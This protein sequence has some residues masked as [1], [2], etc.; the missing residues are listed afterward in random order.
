M[1]KEFDLDYVKTNNFPFGI[2]PEL[3][4]LK[5]LWQ[6]YLRLETTEYSEYLT[7]YVLND[8]TV[9]MGSIDSGFD[10]EDTLVNLSVDYENDLIQCQ[11]LYDIIGKNKFHDI[12]LSD[13][14][15]NLSK[16]EKVETSKTIK[17]PNGTLISFSKFLK[18]FEN[19]SYI[20]RKKI[21]L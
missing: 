20:V 8:K 15:N 14:M 12:E 5:Y 3:F 17:L 13:I 6:L 2:G 11:K 4:S 16:L 1:I 21:K 18:D 7:W 19:A 10:K 9:R